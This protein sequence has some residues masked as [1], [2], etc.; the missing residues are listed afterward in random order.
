MCGIIGIHSNQ[1]VAGSILEGLLHE[2]HRGQDAAGI[3]TYDQGSLHK[4]CRAG[5]VKDLFDSTNLPAGNIGIGHVR[6][7]TSGS[8]KN[9]EEIQPFWLNNPYGIAIAHNGN[10]V[11]QEELRKKLQNSSY[12]HLNT[13]SDS[14]ILLN[15]IADNLDKQ[16]RIDELKLAASYDSNSKY[17][18]YS[19]M[20]SFFATLTQ[21][22]NNT[23]K[24]VVGAYSVVGIIV[25]KGMIAFRDPHGIRPL[26][27]GRKL[28]ADGGYDYLF[29]SESTM[30]HFLGFT[31]LQ[32]IAA[33]E[34]IYIDLAGTI[35]RQI[36]KQKH[37][38]PCIFEYVY[39]ARPDAKIDGVSVYEARTYMGES[40][41][42]AWVQRYPD[43]MPDVVIPAPVTSSTSALAFAATLGIRYSE[44]LYKNPFIGRTFILAN[45][46]ERKRSIRYKLSPQETEIRD[47]KV[48]ILD[49]SI[50]RGNT[51]KEIV[52]MLRDY[53][54]KKVYL[55]STCPP[56]RYP[57]FYGI[58]IPTTAELIASNKSIEEIKQYLNVDEL[59]Y[60]ELPDLIA[61]VIRKSATFTSP[62][63]ACM[64]GKYPTPLA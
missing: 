43:I 63:T 21:A 25:G 55:V 4:V 10:L 52:K 50:V 37:F 28:R 47:K 54:A 20:N 23:Y 34:L 38:T 58:D 14:E 35:H 7:A 30:F 31:D 9:Y 61:A 17:Q 45:N 16:Q 11:N 40:L 33:G 42:K 49:D 56:I 48:L 2:Q 27:F 8:A 39:F 36:I 22:I 13:Q 51:S 60:Q 5:L 18:S 53:G 29:A 12:R 57:C 64:N 32:D 1:P 26:V 6:Y 46:Q 3:L 59:L 19:S 62:C 41:A 15:I 44:G 24:T